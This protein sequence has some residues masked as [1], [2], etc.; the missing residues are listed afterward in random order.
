MGKRKWT[1]DRCHKEALKYNKRKD[2]EVNSKAAY[3]AA[4]R[5]GWLNEI[6]KHMV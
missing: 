4:H 5:H 6:C 3:A 1:F 2:F